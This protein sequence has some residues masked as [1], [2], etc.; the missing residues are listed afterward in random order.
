MQKENK[1]RHFKDEGYA[2]LYPPLWRFPSV[3]LILGGD[4][5]E[6]VK[7]SDSQ[8][9]TVT[10][11]TGKQRAVFQWVGSRIGIRPLSSL[12]RGGMLW[13]R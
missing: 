12:C 1:A 9:V 13:G 2:Y 8:S 5:L 6:P 11:L 10:P 3:R 4:R 7:N